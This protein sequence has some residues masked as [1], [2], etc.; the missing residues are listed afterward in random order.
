[1]NINSKANW[2]THHHVS[3]IFI[4]NLRLSEIYRG[5]DFPNHNCGTT[6]PGFIDA[7]YFQGYGSPFLLR[8]CQ[9]PEQPKI[10]PKHHFYA[11]NL[12]RRCQWLLGNFKL[13]K[14]ASR[15][16]QTQYYKEP[17][18]WDPRVSAHMFWHFI[19]DPNLSWI[20]VNF[21]ILYF[22]VMPCN[23]TNFRWLVGSDAVN[24]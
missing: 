15:R 23:E 8:R 14:M 2:K 16:C 24:I 3:R 10:S 22:V 1:M 17:G 5:T 18:S 20:L 21:N 13:P 6:V 12:A 11:T 4:L 9:G 19:I 7:E